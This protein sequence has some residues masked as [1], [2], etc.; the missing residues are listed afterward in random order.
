MISRNIQCNYIRNSYILE[1]FIEK[2]ELGE[3]FLFKHVK[4]MNRK[5]RLFEKELV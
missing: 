2:A 1:M 3:G 5:K 4:V